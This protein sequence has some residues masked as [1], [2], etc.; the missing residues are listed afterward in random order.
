ME[1]TIFTAPTCH[2]CHALKRLLDARKIRYDEIDVTSGVDEMAEYAYYA[3]TNQ[4]PLIKIRS[5]VFEG[6]DEIEK[7]I[8]KI[9]SLKKVR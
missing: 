8:E 5:F 6:P 1:M 3:S 2:Q 4:L 7:A 9:N